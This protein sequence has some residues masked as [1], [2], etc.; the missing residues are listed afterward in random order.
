MFYLKNAHYNQIIR[1]IQPKAQIVPVF[2]SY[3]LKLCIVTQSWEAT[4]YLLKSI[5]FLTSVGEKS[6]CLY[7]HFEHTHAHKYISFLSDFR[8]SFCMN[9]LE[10][11]IKEFTHFSG[12]SSIPSIFD[13]EKIST[14]EENCE[15]L[16]KLDLK[17]KHLLSH[18][19]HIYQVGLHLGDLRSCKWLT[20]SKF[21]GWTR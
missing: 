14:S 12:K 1:I 13:I 3:M 5:A 9:T 21:R 8:T 17:E 19:H 2:T 6:G 16:C 18:W 20:I 15:Y 4:G 7:S 11:C 10:R